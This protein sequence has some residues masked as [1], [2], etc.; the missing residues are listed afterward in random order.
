MEKCMRCGKTEDIV[1]DSLYIES[2]TI[3][4]NTCYDYIYE[5]AE[6]II[7]Q[8]R[9]SIVSIVFGSVKNAIEEVKEMDADM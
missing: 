9:K 8:N 5:R 6:E 1:K 7:C 4:C 2:E 3:I